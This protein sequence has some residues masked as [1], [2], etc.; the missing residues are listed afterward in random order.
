IRLELTEEDDGHKVPISP[1]QVELPP[2]LRVVSIEPSLVQ[3]DLAK[4]LRKKLKVRARI[5]GRPPGP[6]RVSDV[7]VAPSDVS[8]SGPQEE[9]SDRKFIFTEPID[10][11]GR[12][13][14][15]GT[16]VP[17]R[18]ESP[19]VQVDLDGTVSVD[20]TIESPKVRRTINNIPVQPVDTS[21]AT[22]TK[23]TTVDVTVEGPPSLV[24]D[25]DRST[26]HA[27]IDLSKEDGRPPGTFD[28]KP[29]VK[30]IPDGVQIVRIHPTS[31]LVTTRPRSKKSDSKPSE[32]GSKPAN[33]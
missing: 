24:Q 21:Y 30:N 33:E 18:P 19:L 16:R 28:K 1:K 7:R 3:V 23:P 20:V 15:F 2:G 14:S 10:V 13:R 29:T 12:T 22:A 6:H 26:L 8:A 11:S 27:V 17:L 25:I 5:V 9:L 31:F 4:R 32:D